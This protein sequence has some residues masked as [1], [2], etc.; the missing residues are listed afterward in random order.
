MSF[1][2]S[3][4]NSELMFTT[5]FCGPKFC[6][7]WLK[8][9]KN[10]GQLKWYSI[11]WKLTSYCDQTFLEYLAFIIEHWHSKLHLTAPI[12]CQQW[13]PSVL[14][15]MTLFYSVWS[16]QFIL[17]I[18]KNNKLRF[19]FMLTLTELLIKGPL[20]LIVKYESPDS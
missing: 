15:P 7:L 16:V 12:Q 18:K 8:E 11:V 19:R 6:V 9:L 2:C 13:C 10:C 20:W 4:N 3:L 14:W 1:L 5:W 17:L